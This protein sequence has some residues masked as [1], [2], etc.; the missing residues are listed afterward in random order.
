[1]IMKLYLRQN[2]IDLRKINWSWSTHNQLRRR[3]CTNYSIGEE[4]LK[5]FVLEEKIS[6]KTKRNK[7]IWIATYCWCSTTSIK[8]IWIF[9][10]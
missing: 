10:L 1:M 7:Y 6:L 9:K 8:C 2:T 3:R 4:L 5:K